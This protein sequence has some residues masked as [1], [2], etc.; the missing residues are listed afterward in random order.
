M[1]WMSNSSPLFDMRAIIY[2]YL[3]LDA[4]LDH[5]LLLKMP[6]ASCQ[7]R[8][9]TC[10]ACAGNAGNSFTATAGQRHARA[11]MHAG[12]ANSSVSFE[13]GGGENVPGIPGACATRYFTYLVRGSLVLTITR[14]VLTFCS[15]CVLL[16]HWSYV[17][18]IIK[19]PGCSG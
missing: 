14:I 17:Q 3:N 18:I 1:I 4:R 6:W 10:C 9:I 16:S 5:L 15:V 12:I 8:E 19:S 11:V 7:I 2:P 13:I